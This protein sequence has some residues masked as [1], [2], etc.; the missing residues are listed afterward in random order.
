[1]PSSLHLHLGVH[2]TATTHFQQVLAETCLLASSEYTV[3][4]TQQF[5]ARFTHANRFLDTRHGPELT[6]YMERL[7]LVEGGRVLISEENLIGEAKDFISPCALYQKAEQRLGTFSSLVPEG[8]KTN[9]WLFIRSLDSF[10]PAMYCE[11]LRHWPYVPFEQVLGGVYRQSWI[12]LIQIIR[13]IMPNAQLNV[14][15]YHSYQALAPQML[16]AMTGDTKNLLPMDSRVIRPRL[17]NVAVQLSRYLPKHLP[18]SLRMR[19]VE[20][21]SAVSQRIGSSTGFA[22]FPQNAV[23]DLRLAFQDDLDRIRSMPEVSLFE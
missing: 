2:K 13:S 9:V 21:A 20:S 14:L 10:L 16:R 11:Y 22:P 7:L 8:T 12:P 23:E 5:R 17:T 18:S 6:E 15:N 1:M 3:V 4:T 19:A